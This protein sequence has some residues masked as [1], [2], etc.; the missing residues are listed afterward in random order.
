MSWSLCAD[1]CALLVVGVVV[2]VDPPLL[3]RLAIGR[4]GGGDEHA[5]ESTATTVSPTST[6]G[7]PQRQRAELRFLHFTIGLLAVLITMNEGV[8]RRGG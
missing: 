6:L 4:L 7:L 1:F 5:A 2:V 8:V 3:G